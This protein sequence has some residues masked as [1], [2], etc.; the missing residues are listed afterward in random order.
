MNRQIISIHRVWKLIDLICKPNRNVDIY[1]NNNY[2]PTQYYIKLR[3]QSSKKI[4]EATD[5]RAFAAV[6]LG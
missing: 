5:E 1:L 2:C 6:N 3:E 4:F